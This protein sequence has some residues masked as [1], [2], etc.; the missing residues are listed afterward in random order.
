MELLEDKQAEKLLWFPECISLENVNFLL[1]NILSKGADIKGQCLH[2]VQGL[3][4][5]LPTI[6]WNLKNLNS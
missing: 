6:I 1:E 2:K 5:G 3:M 4:G